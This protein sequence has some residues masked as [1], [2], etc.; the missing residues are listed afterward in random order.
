MKPSIE[1][2]TR[3]VVGGNLQPYAVALV[4]DC[5]YNVEEARWGIVLEWPNAP[6]GSAFSRVWETDEGKVWY[7]YGSCS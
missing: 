1:K 5:V 3:V 6:G 4:A 2:G 7:R